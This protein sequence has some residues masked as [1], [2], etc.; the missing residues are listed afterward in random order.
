MF[1]LSLVLILHVFSIFFLILFLLV[2]I[3]LLLLLVNT[4]CLQFG[5]P[6]PQKAGDGLK[7]QRHYERRN[8]ENPPFEECTRKSPFC[9]SSK[10][11][12]R[13]KKAKNLKKHCVL[14]GDNPQTNNFQKETTHTPHKRHKNKNKKRQK[15]ASP[16]RTNKKYKH[17]CNPLGT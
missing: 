14:K 10:R 2:L 15:N 3:I 11:A 9:N 6:H 8:A 16:R 17:V 12:V 13:K 5:R 4:S 1:D 7:A